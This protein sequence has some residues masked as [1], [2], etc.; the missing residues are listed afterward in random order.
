M[1]LFSNYCAVLVLLLLSPLSTLCF[2]F[3]SKG[4]NEGLTTVVISIALTTATTTAVLPSTASAATSNTAAIE[5]GKVLFT[6]NCASCHLNGENVMNPKRDLKKETLLK[7]FGSAA[8]TTDVLDG[9]QIVSWIE[10]SGQHR[11]MF[12]PN[13]PNGR[14]TNENYEDAISFIVDQALNDKW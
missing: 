1:M 2:S 5:N 3:P 14:M 6:Q 13:V 10:K 9:Q 12:F 8:G 7:F 4:K 11:R